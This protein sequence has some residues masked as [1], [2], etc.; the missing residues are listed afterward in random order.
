MRYAVAM[1]NMS[2]YKG[3]TDKGNSTQKSAENAL[4]AQTIEQTK[5]AFY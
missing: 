3:E 5:M 1:D 2:S 4:F